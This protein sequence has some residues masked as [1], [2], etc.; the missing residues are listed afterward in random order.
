MERPP[1]D[2]RH[3]VIPDGP[4]APRRDRSRMRRSGTCCRSHAGE[5]GRV[6][7]GYGTDPAPVALVPVPEREG[8]RRPGS[9]GGPAS[10]LRLQLG[11]EFGAVREVISDEGPGL[12]LPNRSAASAPAG[13]LGRLFRRLPCE[14]VPVVP[15]KDRYAA[16]HG[17][18]IGCCRA[19]GGVRPFPAASRARRETAAP[20]MFRSASPR[21]VRVR[22]KSSQPPLPTAGT[23]PT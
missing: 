23:V 22:E 3:P 13:M 18:L 14:D 7:R 20:V 16:G 15:G 1:H 21:V 6:C 5:C 11:D 2:V 19:L 4:G 10:A 9:E 12:P 17:G 8:I